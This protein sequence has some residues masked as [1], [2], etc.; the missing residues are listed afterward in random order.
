MEQLNAL[1]KAVVAQSVYKV[2]A[3][4]VKT[5]EPGNIRAE[6]DAIAI[7]DNPQ[8]GTK[9]IRINNIKVGT[10]RVNM[11]EPEE[12]LVITVNDWDAYVKWAME[13][14]FAHPVVNEKSV[15]EWFEQTGEMPDGASVHPEFSPGGF[16]NT[17]LTPFPEK[18]A[19]ALGS[20]LPATVA[21]LLEGGAA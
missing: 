13:N 12:R 20:E 21:G 6:A 18:L 16:K 19:Q 14:G 10:I 8:G 11:A 4:A 5:N 17:T 7:K 2:V 3:K 1:Q 15:I 9:E